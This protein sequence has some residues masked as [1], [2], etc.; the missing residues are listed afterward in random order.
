MKFVEKFFKEKYYVYCILFIVLCAC[1][2]TITS[3]VSSDKYSKE[4]EVKQYTVQKE[5]K[6]EETISI[7]TFEQEFTVGEANVEEEEQEEEIVKEDGNVTYKGI[8]VEV[9]EVVVASMN[10][11]QDKEK[12][13]S[14]SSA[15]NGSVVTVQEAVE[16]Y[17]NSGNS[18]GIDVSKWQGTIN[19]S[20]VKK[21]GIE[22]AMIRIGYRGS[23]SGN[24]FMDPKFKSNVAGATSNGIKVGLYFFSMAKDEAEAIQEAAWTVDIAKNYKITY[25][26]AYDFES[27]GYD[28]MAGISNEQIQKNALA[29]LGYVKA[30][31]YSGMM[32]GSKNALNSRFSMSSFSQYKVWLAHY[33][34][35]TNYKGRYNMWQYTDKG[36]VPGISGYVDM[37]TAYFSY[38]KEKEA[39]VPEPEEKTPVDKNEN[40]NANT[41]IND[42]SNV[43]SNSDN[44]TITNQ[45]EDNNTT[46]NSS[47]INNNDNSNKDNTTNENYTSDEKTDNNTVNESDNT[48]SENTI[49]NT[50]NSSKTDDSSNEN[51][52]SNIVSDVSNPNE[53]DNS[54]SESSNVDNLTE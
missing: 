2:F 50:S 26:I 48:G 1:M 15:S 27:W 23:T 41:S 12:Q 34:E 6:P 28:R 35:S 31:G 51:D 49:D 24:I 30:S 46:N 32:Y 38:S 36:S 17:E 8:T 54:N 52:N 5:E 22:F 3:K 21:S 20:E 16:L 13:V 14:D 10:D 25:P 29:F 11:S 40:N 43:S 33:T 4:I 7:K 45:K 9:P 44:N 37:N 53:T 47:N 39:K 42:N 18:L 19:W